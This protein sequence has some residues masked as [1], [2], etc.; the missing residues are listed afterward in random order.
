M[1]EIICNYVGFAGVCVCVCAV[2]MVDGSH[3]RDS[4]CTK[5]NLQAPFFS[6]QDWAC[7]PSSFT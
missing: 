2:Q 7:G 5:K 3:G 4:W 1:N 6:L